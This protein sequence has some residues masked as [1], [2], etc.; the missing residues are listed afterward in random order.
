M[1]GK[2]QVTTQPE[3]AYRTAYEKGKKLICPETGVDLSKFHPDGVRAHA[4]NLFPD[5]ARENFSEEARARK[6][7]LLK[8]AKEL[9]A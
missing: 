2:P 9:E 1:G 8:I 4:E 6:A 7:T 3:P 5:Y